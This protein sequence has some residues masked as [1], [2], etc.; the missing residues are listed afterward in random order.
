MDLFCR[1]KWLK[2]G[3]GCG[4]SAGPGTDFWAFPQKQ[5][6]RNASILLEAQMAS[7]RA[8]ERTLGLPSITTKEELIDLTRDAYG[9]NA[10]PRTDSL[11]ILPIQP[12]RCSSILLEAHSATT[13][14]RGRSL[15]HFCK[16]NHRGVHR[17]C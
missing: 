13:R 3:L 11:A 2:H 10:G 14:V 4:G 15:L 12:K 17:L 9:N 6:K 5:Q 8:R 16:H 7:T 1:R